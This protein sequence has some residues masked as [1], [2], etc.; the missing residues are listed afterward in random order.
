MNIY[1]VD[2]QLLNGPYKSILAK[3]LPALSVSLT[4]EVEL[5]EIAIMMFVKSEL[6][7]YLENLKGVSILICENQ[8][9]YNFICESKD[10]KNVL[11]L[12]PSTLISS[13]CEW[14]IVANPLNIMGYLRLVSSTAD[15]DLSEKDQSIWFDCQHPSVYVEESEDYDSDSQSTGEIIVNSS[16]HEI[17][18]NIHK[19]CANVAC[20]FKFPEAMLYI[21]S[22]VNAVFSQENFRSTMWEAYPSSNIKHVFTPENVNTARG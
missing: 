4:S 17:E 3:A 16:T 18:F 19:D 21:K 20:L 8:N 11:M 14:N 12:C 6:K 15:G 10:F 2:L 13:P 22:F 1:K 9:K 7:G 5:S